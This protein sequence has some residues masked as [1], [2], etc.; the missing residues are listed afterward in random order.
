M[1]KSITFQPDLRYEFS[2]LHAKPHTI[3]LTMHSKRKKPV[4]IS[5][6]ILS[7]VLNGVFGSSRGLSRI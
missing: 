4:K 5:S 6:S 7:T 3:T 2:P 1:K